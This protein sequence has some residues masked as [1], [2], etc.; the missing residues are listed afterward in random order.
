MMETEGIKLISRVKIKIG[1]KIDITDAPPTEEDIK[2]IAK[3]DLALAN[4][5]NRNDELGHFIKL[6][7]EPAEM[8]LLSQFFI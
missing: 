5:V 2:F 3:Q 6:K 4:M 7:N 1:P 8:A